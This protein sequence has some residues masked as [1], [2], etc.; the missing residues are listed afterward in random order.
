VSPDP[1]ECGEEP[2]GDGRPNPRVG[3]R[4]FHAEEEVNHAVL[5]WPGIVPTPRVIV[6]YARNAHMSHAEAGTLITT[7]SPHR[8]WDNS[9]YVT[10]LLQHLDA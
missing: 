2:T 9:P 4:R 7:I 10:R 8:S 1:A 3:C 5:Q 6:D